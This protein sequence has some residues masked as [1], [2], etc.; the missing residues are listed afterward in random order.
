MK[1]QIGSTEGRGCAWEQLTPFSS[2]AAGLE[3]G[4]PAG[5]MLPMGN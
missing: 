3:A 1:E 2:Y 5:R 4:S